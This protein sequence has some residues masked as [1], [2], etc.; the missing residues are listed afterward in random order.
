MKLPILISSPA[1]LTG[2]KVNQKNKK[3]ILLTQK[4]NRMTLTI[5]DTIFMSAKNNTEQIEVL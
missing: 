5:T 1:G 2:N 3:K 4:P